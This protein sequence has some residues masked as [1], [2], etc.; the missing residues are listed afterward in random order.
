M[1]SITKTVYLCCLICLLSLSCTE[2][3]S[4]LIHFSNKTYTITK[5]Q[6]WNV[7]ENTTSGIDLTL[8][9]SKSDALATILVESKL[10]ST[11]M[12]LEQYSKFTYG[13]LCSKLTKIDKESNEEI[14]IAGFRAIR[15]TFS[16]V[17]NKKPV[18]YWHISV[19]TD[20][21][22]IQMFL[23]SSTGSFAQQA[24]TFEK[25]MHSLDKA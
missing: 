20:K 17:E 9:H 4:N 14:N 25:I 3:K 5:P 10:Q 22:Y 12:T 21:H 18:T 1:S 19:E 15:R 2:K 11:G 24:P 8:S 23:K 13:L 6:D 16:A 7:K